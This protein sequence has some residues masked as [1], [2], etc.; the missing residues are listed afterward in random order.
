VGDSVGCSDGRG[1][2]APDKYV[3]NKVGVFEGLE[4]GSELGL[5]VGAPA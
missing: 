1:V 5:G 2:G 3:G 4:E